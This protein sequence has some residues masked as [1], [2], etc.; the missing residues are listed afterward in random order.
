MCTIEKRGLTPLTVDWI[1]PD[2]ICSLTV[3][4]TMRSGGCTGEAKLTTHHIRIVDIPAIIT[5]CSPD[6]IHANLNAAIVSTTICQ[7]NRRTLYTGVL[8]MSAVMV[9]P[10]K[11]TA[12]IDVWLTPYACHVIHPYRTKSLTMSGSTISLCGF[13][14]AKLPANYAGV[15]NIPAMMANGAPLFIVKNFN[16]SGWRC[17]TIKTNGTTYNG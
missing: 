14:E 12:I 3:Y 10:S 17:A 9:S 11:V 6:A 7:A 15:S 8:A 16:S 1:H 13:W 5:H 4:C 2:W